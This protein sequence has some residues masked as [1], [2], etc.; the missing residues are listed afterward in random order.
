[1]AVMALAND[2]STCGGEQ[3]AKSDTLT[4]LACGQPQPETQAQARA[5]AHTH[6]HTH[7]HKLTHTHG[8]RHTHIHAHTHTHTR[9][10]AR[11]YTHTYM[12]RTAAHVRPLAHTPAATATGYQSSQPAVLALR[13]SLP[14]PSICRYSPKRQLQGLGLGSAPRPQRCGPQCTPFRQSWPHLDARLQVPP[15][16]SVQV[17]PLVLQA[18]G[19]GGQQAVG[20]PKSTASAGQPRQ[21][22]VAAACCASKHGQ[23]AAVA[24]RSADMHGQPATAAVARCAGMHGQPLAAC[25]DSLQKRQRAVHAR[26]CCRQQYK[27][28]VQAARQ[29]Q[30]AAAARS[31]KMHGRR[32]AAA[33]RVHAGASACVC[34]CV[35][36]QVCARACAWMLARVRA[37]CMH[38][39]VRAFVRGR[40]A[41]SPANTSS[42]ATPRTVQACARL[43]T[44]G[45][46]APFRG[47]GG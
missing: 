9:A 8:H 21:P 26:M 16:V 2:V 4:T 17:Q 19:W 6:T 30:P 24:V 10:R 13:V 37:A 31:A 15:D 32:T 20:S 38:A 33:T 47:R 36:S 46:N 29:Q 43:R 44:I 7:T 23:W 11:T 40:S 27:R 25:M 42:S 1:M 41:T 22:A 45:P 5:R 12:R 34:M 3:V 14:P 35:R 18:C 28:T 39:R